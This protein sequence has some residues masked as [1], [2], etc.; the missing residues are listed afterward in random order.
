MYIG[1]DLGSTNIKAAI[2]DKEFNLIDRQSRP[3]NYIR[4]YGFVE[5]DAAAYC[6]DLLGLVADM[7]K[8]NGVSEVA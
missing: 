5:F 4:D 7:V 8:A 1:I 6:R 3:V 2:Y